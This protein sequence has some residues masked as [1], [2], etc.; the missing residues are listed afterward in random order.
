MVERVHCAMRQKS[1][2][3]ADDTTLPPVERNWSLKRGRYLYRRVTNIR[4]KIALS[5][6][7]V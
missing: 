1:A 4:A 2:V 6:D 3:T 7:V 5:A